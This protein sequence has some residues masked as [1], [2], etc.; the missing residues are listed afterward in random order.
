MVRTIA[1]LIKWLSAV[2]AI[3]LFAVAALALEDAI[4][5]R[6]V[7]ANGAEATAL[8][9]GGAK[10]VR[11]RIDGTYWVDLV[12]RDGNEAPRTSRGLWINGALAKQLISGGAGDPPALLI[13]YLPAS[14]PVIVRQAAHDQEANRQQMI[15]GALGGAASALLFLWLAWLGRRRST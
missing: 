3:T 12:W 10:A 7:M 14:A 9:D 6:D 5:V 11:E 15:L 4:R 2:A 13:K 1:D 8:V